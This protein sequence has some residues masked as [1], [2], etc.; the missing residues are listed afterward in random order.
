MTGP[1]NILFKIAK[2]AFSANGRFLELRGQPRLTLRFVSLFKQITIYLCLA[3]KLKTLSKYTLSSFPKIF[4][5]TLPSSRCLCYL[6]KTTLP[7]KSILLLRRAAIRYLQVAAG[8]KYRS[9]DPASG[10]HL[11]TKAAPR[12]L[13]PQPKPPIRTS[14]PERKEDEEDPIGRIPVRGDVP[15]EWLR[16]GDPRKPD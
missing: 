14:L 8:C 7:A 15:R 4:P 3:A 9:R 13:T 1:L 11:D 5:P 10:V 12:S 16:Q 6:M 2:I